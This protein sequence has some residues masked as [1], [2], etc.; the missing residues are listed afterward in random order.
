MRARLLERAAQLEALDAA[1][2]DAEGGSSRLVL[3][4][5]E[6][7]IGKTALLRAFM[8]R[9]QHRVR[10]LFGACD[11]LLAPRA[12]GPLRDAAHSGPLAQVLHDGD[13]EAVYQA[14]LAQLSGTAVPA[15]LVIEDLHWIDEATLDALRYVIR[16]LDR[17]R[18]V[19]VLSYRDDEI[20][21]DHPVQLLLGGLS[22]VPVSRLPLAPLSVSAVRRLSSEADVDAAAVFAATRGNP[23]FV[24]ETLATPSVRVPA[25][26]VDAVMWR[27]AGLTDHA[28]DALA[29]LAV[30]PSHVERR[31]ADQLLDGLSTLVE[32]EHLGIIEV[33]PEGLAFRHEIA[34]RA[35]AASLPASRR[36]SLNRRVLGA[37]LDR[38]E[39]DHA[40][41]VHHAVA[42]GEIDVILEHGPPAARE[43][44]RLGSH[45]QALQHYEQVIAHLDRLPQ[46]EQARLLDEYAWQLYAAQ[47][48]DDA[49]RHAERAVQ[50]REGLGDESALSRSLVVLSRAAYMAERPA[51]AVSAID[52]AVAAALVGPDQHTKAYALAYKGALLKLTDHPSESLVCLDE[53]Q[54]FAGPAGGTDLHALCQIYR[55]GALVDLGDD[56]GIDELR[57]GLRTA[58]SV[59]H[60]EYAARAYTNLAEDLLRLRRYDELARCVD[61]GL[62]FT[63]DHEL[64]GHAYNLRANQALMLS[65]RGDWSIAERTIRELIAEIPD[66]GEETRLT[67][68]ALGR[69]LARRG[70]PEAETFVR[71]GWAAGL[72]G[73]ALQSLGPAAVAM[74]EWAWLTG[75]VAKADEQITVLSERA[76]AT[77]TGRRW[78]GEQLTYLHRAGR[79]VE[80]CPG[81]PEEWQAELRGDW[82]T[83]AR[84]WARIGDRYEQAL[85]LAF[86]GDADAA[87]T[88]LQM[89]AALGATAPAALA[90]TRLR[91]RGLAPQLPRMRV[92][93]KY[94]AGLTPRQLDVLTLLAAGHTNAEIAARL[95]VS[96]RTVDHHVSAILRRLGVSTRREAVRAAARTGDRSADLGGDRDRHAVGHDVEDRG[97]GR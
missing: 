59:R 9:H 29:Q 2:R 90:R 4:S 40:R 18:A 60:F 50:L 58:L 61:E 88:G 24:T 56:S 11:D 92:D 6:A 37:L 52:R 26:V 87:V 14:L 30:V 71:A 62:E 39:P 19:V 79:P 27:M 43:A 48:H 20:G 66:A 1:V 67:L 74:V 46:P 25:T 77:A 89:L 69:L 33:R 17:L 49:Q 76:P 8:A 47:R 83:A 16:R 91:R 28:R 36:R 41:I 64:P 15:V 32:A 78:L 94:P 53:A 45:Q 38:P 23:F 21:P 93:R 82:Q 13:R 84:L 31:L 22:G 73:D 72:R 35:V 55:G 68:P 75:D 3:V 57:R 51:L 10:L 54:R 12:F 96:R 81:C 95:A 63:V 34:R 97:A 70:D 42:A 7:G 44:E 65:A 86:S 80:D 85:A 5:G